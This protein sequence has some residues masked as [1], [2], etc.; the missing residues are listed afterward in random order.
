MARGTRTTTDEGLQATSAKGT[1]VA[2]K[3]ISEKG[4]PS[5]SRGHSQMERLLDELPSGCWTKARNQLFPFFEKIGQNYV[6]D[7]AEYGIPYGKMI[8]IA[9]KVANGFGEG[10]RRGITIARRDLR[11]DELLRS[12]SHEGWTERDTKT[13]IQLRAWLQNNVEEFGN[14][15][16]EGAKGALRELAGLALEESVTR[17]L[18]NLADSA[19]AK[20]GDMAGDALT[21]DYVR[22]IDFIDQTTEDHVEQVVGFHANLLFLSIAK[23]AVTS[24]AAEGLDAEVTTA[25]ASEELPE[26][27]RG[28]SPAEREL[29]QRQATFFTALNRLLDSNQREIDAERDRHDDDLMKLRNRVI[30]EYARRSSFFLNE[31]AILSSPEYQEGWRQALLENEKRESAI[32]RRFMKARRKLEQQ[33]GVVLP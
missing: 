4:L 13:L 8:I 3:G 21:G 14:V 30:L 33:H 32:Y 17:W 10:L 1:A 26:P 20:V 15:I 25:M 29:L 22:S 5:D 31:G 12:I 6:E 23:A 2:E 27:F 16:G 24:A 7:L 9:G 11:Y 28:R 19:A 18:G